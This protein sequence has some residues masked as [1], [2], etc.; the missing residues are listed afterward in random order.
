MLLRIKIK[1]VPKSRRFFP[2]D[3]DFGED[4]EEVQKFGADAGKIS[5]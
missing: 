4:S 2:V 5:H 3:L 1:A